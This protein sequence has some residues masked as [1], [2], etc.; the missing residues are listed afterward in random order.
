MALTPTRP[1]HQVKLTYIVNSLTKQ[2]AEIAC[3]LSQEQVVKLNMIADWNLSDVGV[4]QR[5][6]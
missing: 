3:D 4:W 6:V 5:F 1:L 2:R